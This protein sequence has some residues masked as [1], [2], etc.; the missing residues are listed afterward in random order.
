MLTTILSLYHSDP[1][2]TLWRCLGQM[3]KGTRIVLTFS[4]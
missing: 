3:S 2:I 4:F 1:F